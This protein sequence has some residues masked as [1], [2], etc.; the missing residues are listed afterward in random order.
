MKEY[1]DW[2][3]RISIFLFMT[4]CIAIGLYVFYLTGL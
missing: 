4:F 2:T 1:I 3:L